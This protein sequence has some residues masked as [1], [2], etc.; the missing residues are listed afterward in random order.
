MNPT[1]R[2]LV[3]W[4]G[5]AAAGTVAPLRALASWEGSL[6]GV[7]HLDPGWGSICRPRALADLL[8]EVGRV[9]SVR[10]DPTFVLRPIAEVRLEREPL[11]VLVGDGAFEPPDDAAVDALRRH[12]TGGGLLFVDDASGLEDSPFYTSVI[13]LLVRL[14]PGRE[15]AVLAADHALFRSFFLVDGAAG[16]LLVR[17]Y[18]E[19]IHLGDVTPVIVSRNDLCGAWTLDPDGS[20]A[21]D[22]VPG[23][24]RQRRRALELGVNLVMYALTANYKR[25]AVHVEALL[26]R[27]REEGRIP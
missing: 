6:V 14:W 27:M 9:T 21:F 15:L 20:Y 2:A 12:L 5:A 18:V 19:G 25:D 17:P 24:E 4:M 10:V 7:T 1:R 23:G 22:V 13:D 16:R 11:L 26:R 8:G 3:R